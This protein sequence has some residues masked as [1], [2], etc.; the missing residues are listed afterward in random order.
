MNAAEITDKL[1]L[2]SLRHRN[3]YIQ[4]TCATS[5]DG[6]YEGLD[7]LANQLKNKK[8]G[9]LRQVWRAY[10]GQGVGSLGVIVLF[11]L[12]WFVYVWFFANVW[13]LESSDGLCKWAPHTCSHIKIYMDTYTCAPR[14]THEH[15]NINVSALWWF[16]CLQCQMDLKSHVYSQVYS[17]IKH[18][19]IVI[20]SPCT[21]FPNFGLSV[22]EFFTQR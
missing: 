5:G 19:R 7:W 16:L 10:L 1:G 11:G 18:P 8:W 21:V 15:T 3:W 9:G 14:R 22:L 2:H 6:L 17:I 20:I 4:A 12:V 13:L